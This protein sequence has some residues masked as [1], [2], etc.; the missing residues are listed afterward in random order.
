MDKDTIAKLARKMYVNMQI[1]E[2]LPVEKYEIFVKPDFDSASWR[3]Y[4]NKHQIVIGTYIFNNLTID[5]TLK[6]K[7]LYMRAYLYHEL[8]HS[9]WSDKDLNAI[10]LK[11]KK[12]KFSF[13]MFNLFEDARIEE[14]M[15]H[16][17]QK[18][19]NWLKYETMSSAQNPIDIF[20]YL[21]QSEHNKKAI[22][23]IKVNLGLNVEHH[24][25]TVL[26]FY[27]KALKCESHDE[28]IEL[29]KKWYERFPNTPK[30]E[31]E[32]ILKSYIYNVESNY[33]GDDKKFDELIEGLDNLLVGDS[34]LKDAIQEKVLD[35]T[36]RGRLRKRGQKESLLAEQALEVAFDEKTR[37]LLL[38]K[39]KKLFFAPA[40]MSST[41]LPSK[42]LSIKNIVAKNHKIFKRKDKVN[43]VKKRISIV[44]DLSGSMWETIESMRL[45]IDVLDK[46][47]S[48]NL[49]DATLILSGVWNGNSLCEKYTFPLEKGLLERIVPNFEAEGLHNA[50]STNLT[51]LRKSDYV[52]VFTDGM[53]CEGPISKEFY[54]GYGI[55]THAFYIGNSNYTKELK[56]SFDYVVCEKDVISLTNQI[57]TLVK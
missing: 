7:A 26:L 51:L 56:N 17:I 42:R 19:F 15:R 34:S 31:E 25:D 46:M 41:M 48:K 23:S 20:F 36:L 30:Y 12:L 8:A 47:S 55:K 40:R 32:N 3:F 16:H 57:F 50:M 18:K 24:F 49:T 53:I 38:R 4:N 5:T 45:I 52:W 27:K 2:I 6:N 35:K 54:H 9:I 13:S 33:A 37:D 39:M 44:L 43:F 10:V 21:I 29:L 22:E 11:L 14:K 28:I 1:E